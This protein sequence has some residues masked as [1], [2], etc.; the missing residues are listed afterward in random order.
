MH[1]IDD[2]GDPIIGHEPWLQVVVTPGAIAT[3]HIEANQPLWADT[4]I[5]QNMF[6]EQGVA[7]RELSKTDSDGNIV[8]NDLIPGAT[9]NVSF[10]NKQGRWDEGFEFTI[11]PG[12]T[13]DVCDVQV[14]SR[15]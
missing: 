1:F 3:H 13:T 4:I 2:K 10:V 12:E 15:E 6:W 14:P 8:V 11:R 9:Y 5:W 7:R